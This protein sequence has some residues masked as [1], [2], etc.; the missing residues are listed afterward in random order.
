MYKRDREDNENKLLYSVER[1]PL[2]SFEAL[3]GAEKNVYSN[4]EGGERR[5]QDRRGRERGG[6]GKERVQSACMSK[7][8]FPVNL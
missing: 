4:A 5:G 3:E 1:Q 6:G 2:L 8:M 7:I